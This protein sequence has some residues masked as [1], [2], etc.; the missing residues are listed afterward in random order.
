MNVHPR[1]LLRRLCVVVTP[2][3]DVASSSDLEALA[4]LRTA[5]DW[6]RAETLLRAIIAWDKG[7]IFLVREGALNPAAANPRA[8]IATTSAIAAGPVGVIGNVITREDYRRR[9]LGRVVMEEALA[10][11]RNT[12]VRSVLLDATEDGR[13][14]YRKL[15][16]VDDDGS[17][18]GYAPLAALDHAVLARIAGSGRAVLGKKS[19]LARV[20]ALDAAAFGG[21]RM[22]FLALLLAIPG[23]WLY[24]AE[25]AAG[26]PTG[27][28]LVRPLEAPYVG[29]RAGPWVARDRET[30]AALLLAALAPDAPW[31]REMGMGP[32]EPQF[33][34]SL[35]GTSHEAL[36]L[37]AEVSGTLVEDDLIMRLDFAART[38]GA[39][40]V[41]GEG[42]PPIAAHPEWLYAWIAPMIF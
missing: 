7:R 35:P 38:P 36:A 33:F 31:Q 5:Q 4:V 39:T 37:F 16:F 29:M 41:G 9:G 8:P 6:Q 34:I 3:V 19:A 14:L 1:R 22:S 15:G 12:G 32:L 25:D 27:Y 2:H 23:H 28:A 17:W 18:F 11:L 26:A 13:P 21:D 24:L 20:A 10:W 40:T 42:L 30:A